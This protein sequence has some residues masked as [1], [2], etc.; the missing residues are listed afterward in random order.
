MLLF[1]TKNPFNQ[2]NREHSV[3]ATGKVRVRAYGFLIVNFLP[4]GKNHAKT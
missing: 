2:P 3:V 1:S 4:P